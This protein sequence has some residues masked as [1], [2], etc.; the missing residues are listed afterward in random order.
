MSATKQS[1]LPEICFKG[2]FYW[3]GAYVC[4]EFVLIDTDDGESGYT[5]GHAR[6]VSLNPTSGSVLGSITLPHPGM[7]AAAS[8]SFPM[9]KTVQ[10]PPVQLISQPRAA[11]SMLFML[12]R[13]AASPRVRSAL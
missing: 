8:L 4:D 12:K 3:A 7:H 13:T 1:M 2:G 10:A 9:R 11:I 6:I 5:D